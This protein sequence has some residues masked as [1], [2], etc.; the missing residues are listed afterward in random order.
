MKCERY[1]AL[2]GDCHLEFILVRN[3]TDSRVVLRAICHYGMRQRNG[4]ANTIITRISLIEVCIG[5]FVILASRHQQWMISRC[6][7]S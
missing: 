2:V 4:S 7:P 1:H 5:K 6:P 3:R